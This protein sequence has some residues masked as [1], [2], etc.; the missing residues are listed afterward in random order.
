[1]GDSDK[2][3]L[4][5]STLPL[6]MDQY[7]PA[8]SLPL[9]QLF[10]RDVAR[11]A[12]ESVASGSG[13][14][15]AQGLINAQEEEEDEEEDENMGRGHTN[16]QSGG[17]YDHS[18]SCSGHPESSSESGSSSEDEIDQIGRLPFFNNPVFN[19]P[20]LGHLA[21]DRYHWLVTRYL[22]PFGGEPTGI[23]AA[24]EPETYP[25]I[26]HVEVSTSASAAVSTRRRRRRRRRT[27]IRREVLS[28]GEAPTESVVTFVQSESFAADEKELRRRIAEIKD[29]GLS[30]RDRDVRVQQLIT[31]NYYKRLEQ[32]YGRLDDDEEEEVE[33]IVDEELN[34]GEYEEIEEIQIGPNTVRMTA[35]DKQPTY[36]VDGDFGC[37]HYIRG[38]KK[39]CSNC[40]KWYPCRLCHDEKE[41]HTLIRPETKHMYCMHCRTAQE[42][43]QECKNC[44][45]VL[46]RYYCS[47]CKLWDDDSTKNIYHCNDCGICRIG[48]GL[49]KDFFHCKTCQVCMAIQ[50]RDSHRCI[51]HATECDCPIC[52]EFMFTSTETVVF[53]RCG[54]SIH[55]SC[56]TELTKTSYKCPTCTRSVI[57]MEASFRILD[58][59]IESQILPEPYCNWRSIITCNDCSARSNVSFH[60][61]GLKCGTCKSYN[62]GQQ[63][64]IKPEEG[65]EVAT[66]ISHIA[67]S[68][69]EADVVSISN[70]DLSDSDIDAGDVVHLAH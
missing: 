5:I 23:V 61:L 68:S 43:G 40:H 27:H 36:T 24:E 2:L 8:L 33:D 9:P 11:R 53:M 35:A 70:I 15:Q 10:H 25:P 52:G 65:D 54:H 19:P 14:P 64:I 55:Q 62:T 50:L 46:A 4:S 18:D 22:A 45:E 59:E 42:V 51:E 32:K 20:T 67:S 7:F 3:P 44:G 47:I 26:E 39:E 29:L 12:R 58:V 48:E 56:F 1:M 34:E 38:C 16:S 31:E 28:E 6:A 63:K 57:N 13:S 49:G 66:D 17:H 21:I 69:L 37:K 30:E 60:F 41:R